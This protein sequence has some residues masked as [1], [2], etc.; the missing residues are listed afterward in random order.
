MERK[1]KKCKGCGRY[2]W[3]YEERL[4]LC[5]ECYIKYLEGKLFGEEPES[6][7]EPETEPDEPIESAKP[8]KKKWLPLPE[9]EDDEDE[10]EDEDDEE[11]VCGECGYT[12]GRPFRRCP[13]CHEV[14]EW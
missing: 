2:R 7:E 11:Y 5:K 6:P 8:S 3:I 12:A 4:K 9:E 13:E 14:L 10:D 1:Q